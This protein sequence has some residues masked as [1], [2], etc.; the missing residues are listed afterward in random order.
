MKPDRKII[1]H[2]NMSTSHLS[3]AQLGRTPSRFGK[4]MEKMDTISNLICHFL[5]TVNLDIELKVFSNL[6]Y[7]IL[8]FYPSSS[9][10]SILESRCSHVREKTQG[11][12]DKTVIWTFYT[13]K[14]IVTMKHSL[15]RKIEYW[16]RIFLTCTKTD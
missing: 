6:K 10:N 3:I 12:L 5:L 8:W 7:F 14:L 9:R 15:N 16:W 4:K 1:Q 13:W 11:A 2:F